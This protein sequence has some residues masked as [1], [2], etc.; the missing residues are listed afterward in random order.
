MTTLVIGDGPL[1]YSLQDALNAANMPIMTHLWGE[2]GPEKN[3]LSNLADTLTVD[4]QVTMVV[5]AVIADRQI[6][7]EALQ[8]V[9]RLLPDDVP[10]LTCI[11]NGTATE[12]SYWLGGTKQVV[13]WALVPPA[14]EREMVEIAAGTASAAE[15][16]SAAQTFFTDLDKQP[17]EIQD[18]VGGVTARV[19][20][21]LINN[22]AFA[23]LKGVASAADIDKGTRLGTN[24]PMGPLEWADQIG[25]DQVYGVLSALAE[26]DSP[27]RYR[28]A[29]NLRAR[30]QAGH[31]G[32]RTDQGFYP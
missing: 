29:P 11:L 12:A 4:A 15:A 25:L 27:E 21:S 3:R 26:L 16:I 1:A 7:R 10:I 13:G 23:L 31:W 24:Y 9:A 19:L 28:P 14:S 6:K 17:A 22:A 32:T 8:Q 20:C 30:V 2:R 18:S 5:E